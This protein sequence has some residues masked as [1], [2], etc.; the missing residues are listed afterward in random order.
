MSI[1][2]TTNR[3]IINYPASIPIGFHHI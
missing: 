3:T 1:R 2:I